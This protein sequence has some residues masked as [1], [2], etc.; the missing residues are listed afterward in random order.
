MT[1]IIVQSCIYNMHLKITILVAIF[2]QLSK[3][4]IAAFDKDVLG[5]IYQESKT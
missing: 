4:E 5:R 1:R 3:A 2:L